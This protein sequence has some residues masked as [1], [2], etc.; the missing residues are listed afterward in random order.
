[1]NNSYI[2]L[3]KMMINLLMKMNNYMGLIGIDRCILIIS[4][5]EIEYIS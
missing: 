5:A 3:M 1:M 2:I 4:A